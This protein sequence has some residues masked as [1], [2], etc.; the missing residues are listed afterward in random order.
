MEL[1]RKCQ[2]RKVCGVCMP[3]QN[4][5]TEEDLLCDDCRAGCVCHSLGRKRTPEMEAEHDR[6]QPPHILRFKYDQHDPI[7][8]MRRVLDELRG[9][10]L[11]MAED[12]VEV[13]PDE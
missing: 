7:E 5:M 2:C 9:T 6:Q 8:N 12:G 10:S 3:C 1:E 13:P 4:D 11:G